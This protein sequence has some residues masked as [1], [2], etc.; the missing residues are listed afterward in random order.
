MV[1]FLSRGAVRKALQTSSWCIFSLWW[2]AK[3]ISKRK[4]AGL[5]VGAYLAWKSSPKVCQKPCAQIRALNLVTSF[6]DPSF[7]LYAQV[8]AIDESSLHLFR[9]I[10]ALWFSIFWYS[11]FSASIHWARSSDFI[12]CWCVLGVSTISTKV[13]RTCQ[14]LCFKLF[15]SSILLLI[16]LLLFWLCSSCCILG[17][18]KFKRLSRVL[19]ESRVG[20]SDSSNGRDGC[21]SKLG[22]LLVCKRLL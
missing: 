21:K 16:I 22:A 15:A 5:P 12:A 18:D 19:A 17:S 4:E 14:R 7:F 20:V 11:F 2:T 9:N 3:E 13:I 10:Q 1:T 6:S 8:K